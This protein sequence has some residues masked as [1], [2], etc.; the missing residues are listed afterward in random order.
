MPSENQARRCEALLDGRLVVE[1]TLTDLAPDL[2][3]KRY[4]ELQIIK[5]GFRCLKSTLNLRPLYHWKERRIR[6]HVFLC[7]GTSSDMPTFQS[8]LPHG[9]RL[10]RSR[11]AP[12]RG[13]VSIHAHRGLFTAAQAA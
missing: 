9:E 11:I 2:V 12:V 13:L 10:C 5:R 8:T 3:I 4:K 1:T 6:A 7:P